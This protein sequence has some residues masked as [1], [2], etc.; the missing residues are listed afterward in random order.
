MS[1]IRR[2]KVALVPVRAGSQ[3]LPPDFRNQLLAW[4]LFHPDPTTR[5]DISLGAYIHSVSSGRADLDV[6]LMALEPIPYIPPPKDVLEGQLGPQ[7]R[8]QGFDAA[9]IFSWDQFP[10]DVITPEVFWIG[11]LLGDPPFT[12]PRKFS[13]SGLRNSCTS[14]PDTLPS[15]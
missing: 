15:P 8:S 5:R 9:A 1:W 12:S 11:L 13:A 2:K 10:T 7:L 3:A 6:V 14:W 4:A